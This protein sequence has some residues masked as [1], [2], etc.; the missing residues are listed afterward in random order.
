[1]AGHKGHAFPL[2]SPQVQRSQHRQHLVRTPAHAQH[3]ALYHRVDKPAV[4][5]GAQAEVGAQVRT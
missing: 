1:M 2:S 4:T 3:A 5:P